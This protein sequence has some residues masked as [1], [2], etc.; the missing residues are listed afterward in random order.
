[1]A[2]ETIHE[3]PPLYHAP[4]AQSSV[5]T[6]EK[7]P[8]FPQPTVANPNEVEGPQVDPNVPHDG[9]DVATIA[10]QYRDQCQSRFVLCQQLL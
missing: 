5:P 7:A 3:T 2:T 4:G 1:M 8:I 6:S 9:R 10:Q